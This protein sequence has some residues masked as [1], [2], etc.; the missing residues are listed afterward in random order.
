MPVSI[1]GEALR[2][3]WDGLWSHKLRSG[4]TTLGVIFGI[5]AVIGMASIG[6]GARRE[7]LRQIE[8]MGASNILIDEARPEDEREL[9]TAVEKNPKGLTLADAATV[10]AIVGDALRIIPQRMGEWVVAAGDREARLTIVASPAHYFDLPKVRLMSGRAFTW[11]DETDARRVCV[12]GWDARRELFP[13][14]SPLGKRIRVEKQLFTVVGVTDR[15]LVGG[16]IEGVELRNRNRDIY[17]PLETVMKRWPPD[18]G[19][20]EL[21]RIVVQMPGTEGLRR[22]ARLIERILNRRHNGIVDYKVTVPL[23]LLQQH[24][25]TQHIFNIVMGTIASISLLVGGIG[26]MNIMLASVL[27]RTREIGIRRAMG[28]RRID[29][30]RQ[31]L[32]EAVILS[33]SGGIVGV[34]LGVALAHGISMYAGWKTAASGWATDSYTHLTLPTN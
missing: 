33:L 8:I 12:L 7:A 3:A 22:W 24:Q 15:R 18:P 31:F 23:E 6:E 19:E 2:S 34:M 11:L 21:N 25:R 14:G 1:D 4:L 9:E 16:D 30:T 5:A 10:E 26:I 32:T 28:A 20:S 27:E 29:I 13:I 17:V